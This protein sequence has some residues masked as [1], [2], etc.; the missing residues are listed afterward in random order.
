MITL[1]PEFLTENGKPK[2][3]V[4]P[5]EEFLELQR[6]VADAEDLLALREATAEEATAPTLSS[7]EVR[8]QL[9]L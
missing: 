9:G 8:R 6:V 1:H 2:S 5:Y 3:V 4:L 7:D